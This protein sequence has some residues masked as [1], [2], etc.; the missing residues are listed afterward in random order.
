MIAG[1]HILSL[2]LA[3][4]LAV[5]SAT[6]GSSLGLKASTAGRLSLRP[7]ASNFAPLRLKGGMAASKGTVLVTGGAGYI[8]T[9]CTVALHE[10]GYEVS[11]MRVHVGFWVLDVDA[12][13]FRP[14]SLRSTMP[15]DSLTRVGASRRSSS[16]T[17][18][19]TLA[20]R[21]WSAHRRFRARRSS[22]CEWL[23]P[24]AHSVPFSPPFSATHAWTML[25]GLGTKTIQVRRRHQGQDSAR[26][27]LPG[28]QGQ[29]F[30]RHSLCWPQGC[31]RV[32]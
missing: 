24:L 4:M 22:M 15:A 31:R 20:P 13:S 11:C 16:S 7:S 29:D 1:R 17:T 32:W 5:S 9:H 25:T 21:A 19:A 18:S 2:V 14:S 12:D 6:S 30:V 28:A 10:A 3:A 8:G 26:E 23:R 27:G